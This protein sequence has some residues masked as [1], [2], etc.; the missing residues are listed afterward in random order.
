[1]AIGIAETAVGLAFTDSVRPAFQF[2]CR[3]LRRWLMTTGSSIPR[4]ALRAIASGRFSP[5]RQHSHRGAQYASLDVSVC[6]NSVFPE[7]SSY[8]PREPSVTGGNNDRRRARGRACRLRRTLRRTSTERELWRL[9][10]RHIGKLFVRHLVRY[11]RRPVPHLLRRL[12]AGYWLRIFH[13]VAGLQMLGWWP[14]H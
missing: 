9:R 11:R 1:M 6:L 12:K 10:C 14:T 5:R 4:A 13:C 8:A 3:A 2:A 7:R